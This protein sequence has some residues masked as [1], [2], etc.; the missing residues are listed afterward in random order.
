VCSPSGTGDVVDS[1]SLASGGSLTY[2]V[3]A[4][5]VAS[6]SGS[7]SNSASIAAP[8]SMTD[9]NPGNDS[10]G[11]I[12]PGGKVTNFTHASMD[13]PTGIATGRR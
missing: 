4:V 1:V 12:T 5:V 9:P 11:R 10:V 8:P 7:L 2:V 13:A 6:V 3:T